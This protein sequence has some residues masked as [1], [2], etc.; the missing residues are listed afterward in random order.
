MNKTDSKSLSSPIKLLK[1]AWEEYKANVK[2]FTL[3]LII[4]VFLELFLKYIIV[5]VLKPESLNSLSS[6]IFPF[7]LIIFF[8]FLLVY[9][10]ILFW[11]NTAL[12]LSVV[13]KYSDWRKSYHKAK[14]KIIPLFFIN[15][16]IA[17]LVSAGFVLL[18]IP[19]ILLYIWLLFAPFVY[20]DQN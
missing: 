2:T 12:Y 5:F 6:S 9:I 10:L 15:L 3:I 17:L 13:E 18:I 8:A 20:F 14:N 11:S 16:L 1:K 19:G 7:L 4:P